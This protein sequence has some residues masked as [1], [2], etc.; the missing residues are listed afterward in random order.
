MRSPRRR[1][2]SSA[3]E[4]LRPDSQQQK[5]PPP[6]A[7]YNRSRQ[8]TP[9]R[10]FSSDDDDDSDD[11]SYPHL[12]ASLHMRRSRIPHA[13]SNNQSSSHPFIPTH[14]TFTSNPKPHY[15]PAEP[16]EHTRTVKVDPDG[17]KHAT[18]TRREGTMEY[19][20]AQMKQQLKAQAYNNRL[21]TFSDLRKHEMMLDAMDK[22]NESERMRLSHTR[23]MQDKHNDT[24]LRDR[25]NERKHE[26]RMQE[27]HNNAMIR[28]RDNDRK[29]KEQMLQKQT[30]SALKDKRL[31]KWHEQRMATIE[32][33]HQRTMKDQE[34]TNTMLDRQNDR[35]HQQR[36]A[37]ISNIGPLAQAN[38]MIA[39]GRH[40][41]ALERMELENAR[42]REAWA[43]IDPNKAEVARRRI[44]KI[45]FY[46]LQFE[47]DPELVVDN[48]HEPRYVE[49][50]LPYEMGKAHYHHSIFVTGVREI[51]PYNPYNPYV[52]LE[53]PKEGKIRK[54]LPNG[55]NGYICYPTQIASGM[56][57]I[58]VYKYPPKIVRELH[59]NEYWMNLLCCKQGLCSVA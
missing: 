7:S 48:L 2:V 39:S 17:T 25:Q 11:L 37:A 41:R 3:Y 1:K 15:I 40:Q 18:E 46:A 57:F 29:H 34:Q 58:N 23:Q 28:D 24:L 31:D 12:S 42:K 19:H 5:P 22:H 54:N 8:A 49:K 14:N 26:F 33:R 32:T 44:E 9:R 4:S 30:D 52:I 35:L 20:H 56:Y 16:E 38:E 47:L 27:Q 59:R 50:V 55:T 6:S 53:D 13:E 21:S 10:L 45:R 36:L 51:H 43:I